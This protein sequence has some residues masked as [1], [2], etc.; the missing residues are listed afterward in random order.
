MSLTLPPDAPAACAEAPAFAPADAASAAHATR[1]TPLPPAHDNANFPAERGE[2]W[3]R[4]PLRHAGAHTVCIRYERLGSPLA[5]AV[6][7]LGGIS[8]GR[9]VAA[10]ARFPETGWWND[11]VGAA[12]ALDPRRVQVIAIDWLGADGE[13]DVPIDSADQADALAAV[14]DALAIPRLALL[15]GA[16]YGAMVGLA[17][18]A[19]HSHRLGHLLAISGTERAHPYAS[20]WRHVQRAIVRLGI[21]GG[22]PDAAVALARQLAVLSYRTPVEFAERFGAA[23]TIDAGVATVAAQAYLEAQ[24]TR[25]AARTSAIASLRL[26]ESIDLHAVDP[27]QVR[28][29]VTLVGVREDGLVPLDDTYAL[30]ERLPGPV[31]VRPLQSRY[32]HDA[33]LKEPAAIAAILAESLAAATGVS[34]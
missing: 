25:H 12:R 27:A 13:L 17:F 23:A 30:A 31:Q 15:A 1:P 34:P 19:R 7:V 8:A 28:V 11:Q 26:S 21:A 2:C 22:Q 18:A 6:A 32:G 5:P 14:L 33:F 20:A 29:P 24:G 4:L 16:S 9:H 10:S 3:L